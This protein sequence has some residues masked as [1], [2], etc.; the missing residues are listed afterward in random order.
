MTDDPFDRAVERVEA[1]TEQAHA[2]RRRKQQA[3]WSAGQRKAF[4][5]HATVFVAVQVLLIAVWALVWV[6]GGSGYPWFIYPLLGW[7]IGL[8]AHYAT[9]REHL[10][11]G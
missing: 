6:T 8:A 2:E 4:G 3:Q 5:I 1:A 10:K 11:Q 9:A 7:G